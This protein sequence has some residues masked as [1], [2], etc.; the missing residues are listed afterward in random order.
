MIPSVPTYER[1]NCMATATD[2]GSQYRAMAMRSKYRKLY[3]H[4]CRLPEQEWMT[5]FSEI[6][7][8]LG[9]ELPPSARLYRP[10]WANQSNDGNGH[11]QALAWSAAGWET[12]KVDMNSETLLFRR[13]KRPQAA[14][15]PS[16]DEVWPVRSVGTWPEGLSLNREEIY[17]DGISPT[18]CS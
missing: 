5:S 17:E 7:S 13:C 14:D 8:V 18:Q 6:E 9:L 1:G 11:S 16:L 12:A 2:R 3:A 15:R 4:L 10:W